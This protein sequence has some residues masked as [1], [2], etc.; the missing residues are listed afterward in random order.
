MSNNECPCDTCRVHD[1]ATCLD[2]PWFDGEHHYGLLA[3]E[4]VTKEESEGLDL[5]E[6]R[7]R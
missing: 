7:R 2:F 3:G 4:I 5:Y 6:P 1:C